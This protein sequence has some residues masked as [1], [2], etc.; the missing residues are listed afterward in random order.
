MLELSLTTTATSVHVVHE[1]DEA[2]DPAHLHDQR[3]HLLEARLHGA[4]GISDALGVE[5]QLPLRLT[6]TTIEYH[7]LDGAPF[8]PRDPDLHHRDETLYGLGDPWLLGRA[9]ASVADVELAGKLG[10]TLPLGSTE[11][12]PFALGDLGIRHQHIQLGTGTFDPVAVVDARRRL[13]GRFQVA[14]HGQAQLVLY[15]NARGYRAGSRFAAGLLGRLSLLPS[16]LVAATAD[17]V[18]ERPERWD[19]EI[20]QDGNLGRTDVLAGAGVVCRIGRTSLAASVRIPVYQHIVQSGDEAGQL[21][22]PAIVDLVV[23][24]AFEL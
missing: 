16:L 7:T 14:V 6:R 23:Q 11:D 3:L 8:T 24:R 9:A 15:E 13:G 2:P 22:Y 1:T 4:Y 20:L 12:N 5:L 21:S 18:H 19:G 17:V 10:V